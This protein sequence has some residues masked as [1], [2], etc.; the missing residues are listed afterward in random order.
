[1]KNIKLTIEYDGTD[2]CGWQ[3]QNNNITVQG[4]LEKAIKKATNELIDV[5][6]S[7]RTDAGVHARGMV[8]NFSTNSTIPGERFREAVNRRLPED[9]VIIKSEEVEE[10]FHA[11]YSSKGKTYSY[12]IINKHQKIAIG[13]NFYYHVKDDLDIEQ[14]KKACEY[15]VGKHD[16]QAFQSKGSSVKTT[17]RTIE[18]LYI[19][20]EADIIRV[21]VT[22]DGFLY[23][24][25]RIIVGTLIQVGKGKMKAEDIRSILESCNRLKAGPC[26][27][28]NGLVL[29]EVYY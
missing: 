20:K 7:S 24:M 5:I 28:P 27:K 29:E 21:I 2:Y 18:E 23:N 3:K 4:T 8:C 9:I 1:M 13:K 25:V 14:M 17:I 19:E 26:V 11:R 10:D 22:A 12:T 6:G 15:F 16:F